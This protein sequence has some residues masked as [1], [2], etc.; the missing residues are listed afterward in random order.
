MPHS[1]LQVTLRRMAQP[2]CQH[3]LLMVAGHVGVFTTR[4]RSDVA[5]RSVELF[6][7]ILVRW[8]M[9]RR[10]RYSCQLLRCLATFA[11]VPSALCLYP[12]IPTSSS[13]SH[14]HLHP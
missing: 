12:S 10:L 6:N 8:L 4:T 3:D 7:E 14:F 2:A 13:S 5:R 9:L 1:T 11:S